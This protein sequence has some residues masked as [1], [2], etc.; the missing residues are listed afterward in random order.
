MAKHHYHFIGIAGIGMSALAKLLLERGETVSGF[1]PGSSILTQELSRLGANIFSSHKKDNIAGADI[2]VYSSAIKTGNPELE[3]A[4]SAGLRLMKR[5]ELLAE[6]FNTKSGIA[7]AGSHGKTTTSSLLATVL[8]EAN[9]KPSIAVGGIISH[10]GS[11]AFSGSGDYFVAESDESDGSF[12]FLNPK[13]GIL[14]NIDNDHVDHYGSL[15]Q[16]SSAFESFLARIDK[17]GSI[18]V[19]ADDPGIKN[20][21]AIL[22]NYR[23]FGFEGR[24]YKILELTCSANGSRFKLQS[25]TSNSL[26]FSLPYLGRHNAYNAVAVSSLCLDLGLT[27]Q[28][29]QKGLSVFRGVG[30][31][32]EKIFSASRFTL[33]DDYGHHPTEIRTTIKSIK[34]VDARPL[35]V[36][37]EPHRFTRTKNFWEDFVHCFNGADKVYVSPIYAASES[38]IEGITSEALVEAQLKAGL[39]VEFIPDLSRMKEIKD[40]LL[41]KEAILLTLGAGGISKKIREIVHQDHAPTGA[42]K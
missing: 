17:K 21:P 9:K 20:A 42:K 16:L 3:E 12:L 34:E 19:N 15:E 22:E 18:L 32:L 27:P 29:I 36:V 8:T 25:K 33:I 13:H 2:V 5:G 31:R 6:L 28:E 14:T 7:V 41:S 11:N 38:P 37:F 30:R 39:N 26:E 10:L 24:D 1:D 23:S 40:T 35:T 4:R